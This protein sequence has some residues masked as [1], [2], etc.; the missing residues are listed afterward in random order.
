MAPEPN[1]TERNC[2]AMQYAY[3]RVN[4][5]E[6]AAE[7]SLPRK[8]GM[9]RSTEGKKVVKDVIL[10]A[11]AFLGVLSMAYNITF[12]RGRQ[13]H[14]SVMFDPFAEGYAVPRQS[15]HC[16]STTA[17]ARVL[18]CKYSP[19][20]SAWLPEHCRDD[21]LEL[22]FELLGDGPD[23]HWMYFADKARQVRLSLDEIAEFGND[24]NA[25]FHMSSEWHIT[26]CFFF[27]RWEHRNRFNG[28]FLP[29]R[30]DSEHHIKHCEQ[31]VR[32]G[33]NFQVVSGVT[34]DADKVEFELDE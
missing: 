25:T 30:S 9:L 13:Q 15:C 14:D 23:G 20:A 4:S 24:P 7:G 6:D 31:V 34:L 22:E 28:K 17:E 5:S 26:H 1:N 21:E 3:R 11:L 27:W 12:Y 8:G 29:L 16:G 33:G 18:G 32:G 10:A 2:A 19:L